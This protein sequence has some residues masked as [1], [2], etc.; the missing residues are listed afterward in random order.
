MIFYFIST[1]TGVVCSYVCVCVCVYVYTYIFVSISTVLVYLAPF[2]P[3]SVCVCVCVFRLWLVFCCVWAF[4]I[5]GQQGLVFA[6]VCGL[7]TAAASC[8][9]EHKL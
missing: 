9:V 4:S 2:F 8:V 3:N 5:C 7:L 6:A 1:L